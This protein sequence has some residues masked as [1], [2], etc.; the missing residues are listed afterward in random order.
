MKKY[1]V[2]ALISIAFIIL[3]L[4][5]SASNSIYGFKS[6][7]DLILMQADDNTQI[8]F[9]QLKLPRILLC[10][11]VGMLL[12][13]SAAVVQSVFLNPLADPYIIGI[14][15]A[16]T[17]GAVLAYLLNISEIFYGL[18]A[19]IFSMILCFIILAIYKENKN[20]STLLIL[21]IAISAFLASF[22]SFFIY[23]IGQ[24]SFKITAWL[25]GYFG[26]ATWFKVIIVFIVSLISLTYFYLKRYELDILLCADEEASTLGLNVEKCKKN[27]IIMSC[28]CVSFSV[29]FCG[30][31]AFVGLIIPHILRMFLKN[32]SNVL[33][34]PLS[35]MLGGIFLLAC[36]NISRLIMYPTEIPVGV[37]TSFFGAPF[38]IYL[39][40]GK[41]NA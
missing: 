5:L 20:I 37:I 11:L 22:T 15:S 27:L 23:L 21:G 9:L 12:A 7:L 16:A 39:A 34:I 19:F 13:S 26:A 41:K 24:D 6:L 8:V 4:G 40:L 35:S 36:D 14:A 25:M 2:F 30:M 3:S 31:I 18:F 1:I 10:F 28:L 32:S 17:F 33:I 38:F 29:A